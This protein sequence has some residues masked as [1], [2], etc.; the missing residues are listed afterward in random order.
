[1]Y[2]IKKYLKIFLFPAE[3]ILTDLVLFFESIGSLSVS[4]LT[5]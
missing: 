2:D 3:Q 1:M 4:N 5:Y